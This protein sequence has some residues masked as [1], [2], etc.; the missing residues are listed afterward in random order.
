M[1]KIPTYPYVLPTASEE[2]VLKLQKL[3]K[4]QYKKELTYE[5]S[6]ELLETLMRLTYL[7][8]MAE[9]LREKGIEKRVDA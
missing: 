5:E 9:V 8:S 2:Y 6:K 3:F 4:D 7:T 1:G